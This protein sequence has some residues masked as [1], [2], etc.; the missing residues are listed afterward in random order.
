M[1]SIASVINVP[2]VVN[3]TLPTQPIAVADRISTRVTPVAVSAPVASERVSDNNPQ[4]DVRQAAIRAAPVAGDSSAFLTQV[5]SQASS[6]TLTI[7]QS[8]SRFAPA[9]HYNTLVSYSLVKYKP[10]NAG[11]PTG[12]TNTPL[13]AV[14][15]EYQAYNAAQLRNASLQSHA[16]TP[17]VISG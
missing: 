6:S 11:I 16:A 7:A 1:V 15:G 9:L 14:A 4:R 5:F 8:F 10:S 3:A 2:P 12:A 17:V 13:A